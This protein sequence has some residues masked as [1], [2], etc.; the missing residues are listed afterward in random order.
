MWNFRCLTSKLVTGHAIISLPSLFKGDD[1]KTSDDE[2][3]IKLSEII[4]CL[5]DRFS[6]SSGRGLTYF[7]LK[8]TRLIDAPEMLTRT[9]S[10]IICLTDK[11]SLNGGDEDNASDLDD[12][13][14]S[15]DFN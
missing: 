6:S 10:F 9:E 5:P 14:E 3:H 4:G 15:N 12:D 2:H 11:Q 8:E 1:P 13:M 7:C